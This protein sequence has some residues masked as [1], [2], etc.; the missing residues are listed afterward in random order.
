MSKLKE[1]E[2]KLEALEHAR[3]RAYFRV[4]ADEY[5]KQIKK[6]NQE[7]KRLRRGR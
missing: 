6:I 4:V 3:K 1:L 2:I 7:I 5:E